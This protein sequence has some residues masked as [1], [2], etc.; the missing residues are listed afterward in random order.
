[1]VE[2]NNTQIFLLLPETHEMGIQV[3]I[4]RLISNWNRSQYHD[5][6]TITWEVGPVHLHEPSEVQHEGPDTGIRE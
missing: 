4:D 3:V 2:V 1:M 6:A 5:R